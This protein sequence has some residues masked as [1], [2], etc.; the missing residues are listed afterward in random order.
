MKLANEERV[1]TDMRLTPAVAGAVEEMARALGVPKNAVISFAV[2]FLFV[3]FGSLGLKG[4]KRLD[5]LES[6]EKQLRDAFSEA[7][8][9]A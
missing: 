8:R 2:A 3:G 1:K 7:K 5:L 4:R 9:A 6:L